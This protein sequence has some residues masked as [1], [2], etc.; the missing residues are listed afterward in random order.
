MLEWAFLGIYRNRFLDILEGSFLI[1]VAI[2]SAATL[3]T[4]IRNGNQTVVAFISMA[5]ACATMGGIL[6]YHVGIR[7]W[8]LRCR[9]NHFHEIQIV[10]AAANAPEEDDS[11]S[12]EG[13]QPSEMQ[14]LRLTRD[15]DDPEGGFIF[16]PL[17][18]EATAPTPPVHVHSEMDD[19]RGDRDNYG[20][21][22]EQHP[23]KVGVLVHFVDN[24]FWKL[25]CRRIR[26]HETQPQNSANSAPS[27]VEDDVEQDKKDDHQPETQPHHFTTDGS[28]SEEGISLAPL[29][30]EGSN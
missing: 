24:H 30:N 13:D 22:E 27:N 25:R 15:R 20:I 29:H 14:P 6:I 1:N 4:K 5:T 19:R 16:V 23:S 3:Y 28:V 21:Q 2:F 12:E 26:F 11:S 7:M 10:N 17:H 18:D 8:N 9:R